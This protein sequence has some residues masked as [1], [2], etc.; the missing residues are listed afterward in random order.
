MSRVKSKKLKKENG[1][2]KQGKDHIDTIETWE[3]WKL[4]ERRNGNE[5]G[6]CGSEVGERME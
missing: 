5:V 6:R 3:G 2:G 4:R 1:D